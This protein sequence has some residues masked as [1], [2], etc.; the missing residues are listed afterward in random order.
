[1]FDWLGCQKPSTPLYT[2]RREFPPEGRKLVVIWASPEEF[3]AL[4]STTVVPSR[5][6]TTPE[7]LAGVT[8]AVSVTGW[9]YVE[10]FGEERRAVEVGASGT[11]V[12]SRYSEGPP[13][14][15]PLAKIRP[16]WLML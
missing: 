14:Y 6:S 9:P 8:V 15:E 11:G 10:G 1:M 3:S 2:A 4:A 7:A 16:F 5:N 13:L 12:S